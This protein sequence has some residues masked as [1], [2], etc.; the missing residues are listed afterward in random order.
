MTD[1]SM[2]ALDA[3]LAPYRA[4]SN[5]E[6]EALLAAYE[7]TRGAASHPSLR[8]LAASR[9]MFGLGKRYRYAVA[10]LAYQ[11]LTGSADFEVAARPGA[12]LELYHLYTLFLDDIM[13]EDERRRTVPA[14]WS[15]NG[16]MYR[17]K[18]AARPAR[19]FRTVRHRY[20]A[21]MAI[22]DALRIRSL[23]ER[24]I[25]T[26]P[27]VDIAVREQ[28]LEVLTETDLKLSDGQGLDI[29]FESL[30]RVSEDEYARMSELKTGV[31]YAA[32]AKTGGLL[33]GAPPDRSRWFEEYARRFAW[34]FQDR[35]DLLG[36][37]VVS[38]QIGGSTLGDIEK[39]KRTRLYAIA[40]ARLP[41]AK[42]AAF[43][44]AYGRGPA[45][46]ARDVK[47]VRSLFQEHARDEVTRRIRENVARA[48]SA[49]RAANAV[50]PYRGV[51]ETL[52]RAQLTRRK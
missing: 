8:T 16:R 49:L 39:G 51:L 42:R 26:A 43:A 22:L 11:S 52:A 28:L 4:R 31:L 32:A 21:S 45:T 40:V 6:I 34:A 3:S 20:G 41:A 10:C 24:A 5:R 48:L 36:A 17:R 12:W 2:D 7:G 25:Q 50:E 18:D 1:V 35:D 46:T 30:D 29:D 33:A 19:V 13:D 44:R 37:G 23:A 38:S 15:A 47:L 9:R 14:A 27:K